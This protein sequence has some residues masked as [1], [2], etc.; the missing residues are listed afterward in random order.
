VTEEI[1]RK[2]MY[3]QFFQDLEGPSVD[4]EKSLT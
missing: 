3:G 2:P 4:K 1:K